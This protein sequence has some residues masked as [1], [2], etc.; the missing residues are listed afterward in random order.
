[1]NV[2]E[3]ALLA[4]HAFLHT[5]AVVVLLVWL[6]R[7]DDSLALFGF[8]LLPQEVHVGRSHVVLVAEFAVLALA[9]GEA[10][11]AVIGVGLIIAA[12][13]DNLVEAVLVAQEH[14]L[15]LLIE[16]ALLA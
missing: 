13:S 16:V 10:L 8:W 14:L 7:P 1:M 15:R 4:D 6:K 11:G 3:I 2:L 9:K 12:D 5:A